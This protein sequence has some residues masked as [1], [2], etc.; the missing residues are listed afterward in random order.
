MKAF[1]CIAFR[2]RLLVLGFLR[3]SMPIDDSAYSVGVGSQY[4][5]ERVKSLGSIEPKTCINTHNFDQ[6]T[7]GWDQLW[8][9][10][11]RKKAIP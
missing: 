6:F 3:T 4:D 7:I 2:M 9:S 10:I 5:H 11:A 8:P 1:I